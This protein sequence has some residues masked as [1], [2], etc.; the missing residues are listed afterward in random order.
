MKPENF[1]EAYQAALGT[2]KWSNVAPLISDFA[3][4][5]F[6]NG[7]VH[8]GKDNVQIAFEINFDSIKNERYVIENV[9]WLKKEDDYAVYI[10]EFNW[11][12][13]LDGKSVSGNGVGTST[14]IKEKQTWK[15][16]TEHLGKR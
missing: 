12:G 7:T 14:I 6:S 9:K 4:V 10:F 5:T 16:L 1:I 2:Q 8:L 3:C 11:R 15:L 13:I